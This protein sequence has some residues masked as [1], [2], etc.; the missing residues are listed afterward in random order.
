MERQICQVRD[1]LSLINSYLNYSFSQFNRAFPRTSALPTKPSTSTEEN[2]FQ[3]S[4]SKNSKMQL[5]EEKSETKLKNNN[6]AFN[7][8]IIMSLVAFISLSSLVFDYLPS[9][10]IAKSHWTTLTAWKFPQDA[11]DERGEEGILW[12]NIYQIALAVVA[13]LV[14]VYI[15][16]KPTFIAAMFAFTIFGV[17]HI[18]AH[19]TVHPWTYLPLHYSFVTTGIFVGMTFGGI[20]SYKTILCCLFMDFILIQGIGQFFGVLSAFAI[21]VFG[22]RRHLHLMCILAVGCGL[23]WFGLLFNDVLYHGAHGLTEVCACIGL[24]FGGT[25][26]ILHPDI[27]KCKKS[28]IS[29]N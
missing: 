6:S 4:K 15:D 8:L 21:M 19:A 1:V 10:E 18:T 23:I 7:P 28:I 17:S 11:F 29:K 13:L 2:E 24:T 22:L 16:A 3:Q 27:R 5:S 9:Y 12:A 25:A 14:A 20:T 26:L